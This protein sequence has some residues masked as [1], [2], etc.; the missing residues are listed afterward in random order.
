ML[1]LTPYSLPSSTISLAAQQFGS[2]G[3]RAVGPPCGVP[4]GA[5]KL[6]SHRRK[7]SVPVTVLLQHVE[8]EVRA[9]IGSFCDVVRV[10]ASVIRCIVRH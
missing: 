3:G 2:A 1:A 9:A 10:P 7:N 6:I 5:S 4:S 8:I